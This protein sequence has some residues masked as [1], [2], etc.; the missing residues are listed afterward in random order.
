MIHQT[1][2]DGPRG[3]ATVA[4]RATTGGCP[5]A[6]SQV[7]LIDFF[8]FVFVFRVRARSEFSITLSRTRSRGFHL[9]ASVMI[10]EARLKVSAETHLA[11]YRREPT[12]GPCQPA[13]AASSAI[14]LVC[15]PWY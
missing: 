11:C 7:H 5:Y 9:D 13:A 2:E 10:P 14:R 15:A 1:D 6:F 3:F 12:A 8:G 4:G